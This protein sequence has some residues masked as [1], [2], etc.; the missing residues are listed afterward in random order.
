M[1]DNIYNQE[2]NSP[3]GT[4]LTI[5]SQIQYFLSQTVRWGRFLAVVGFVAAGLLGVVGIV[6]MVFGSSM[7]A[8]V[9]EGMGF[10]SGFLGVFYILMGVLY[11]FPSKYLYDFCRSIK[12]AFALNDQETLV[13]AFSKLKSMFKFFG[14]VTLVMLILYGLILAFSI[15]A[16]LI[17]AI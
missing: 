8:V 17:S 7:E 10:L 12:R 15:I 6:M 5:D 9:P 11:Y 4:S 16:G 14:I 2:A 13:F 3:D 1:E